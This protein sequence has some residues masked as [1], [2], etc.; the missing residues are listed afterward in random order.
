MA[1]LTGNAFAAK[2]VMSV[3]SNR[4]WPATA[5]VKTAKR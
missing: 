4:S 1:T 5:N 3:L 2:Y